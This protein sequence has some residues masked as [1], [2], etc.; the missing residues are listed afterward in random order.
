MPPSARAYGP[1]V[2]FVLLALLYFVI[3]MS[4]A[5]AQ[6]YPPLF[7]G[8]ANG[9]FHSFGAG[10]IAKFEPSGDPSGMWDTKIS[11]GSDATGTPAYAS[12]L[13]I[14]CVR[15]GYTPTVAL[16]ALVL[17]TASP[18]PRRLKA[19]AIGLSLVQAFVAMRV[20]VA[21]LYGF[22][23]VGIGDRHLLEV[24]TLGTTALRLADKIFTGDLHFTYIAP[25]LIWLVVAVGP[26]ATN[27]LH[28]R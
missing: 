5:P 28:R 12:S 13:G 26:E 16:I 25:L 7:R 19:L 11:V 2:R 14:N 10:R 4:I 22:S 24:G 3:L 20:T 18:W 17:A 27:V 23:R 9:L 8:T 21:T 6:F 15:E 1:A